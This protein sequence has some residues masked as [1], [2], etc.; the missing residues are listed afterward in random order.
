MVT[1]EPRSDVVIKVK[2]HLELNLEKN[3]KSKN[4]SFCRYMSSKEKMRENVGPLLHGVGDLVKKDMEKA[5]IL[6]AFFA[7]VINGK[8]CLQ[9][10][11][12]PENNRKIWSKVSTLC[13]EALRELINIT[14]RPLLIIFE[15]P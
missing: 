2:A 10:S 9:E 7:S 6:H 12:G 15:G 5:E 8:I 14:V 1:Q 3:G 11:Q 4:K 13:K